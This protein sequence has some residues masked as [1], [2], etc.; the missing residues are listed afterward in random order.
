MEN[1]NLYAL[2]RERMPADRDAACLQLADLEISW[3]ELDFGVGRIAGLLA[4]LGSEPGARLL[5]QVEKSPEALMLYLAALRAGMVYVPLN[6]AYQEAEL[7]HFVNDSQPATVVCSPKRLAMFEA[8]E[9]AAKIFSLDE[10]GQGTLTQQA[11]DFDGEFATVFCDSHQPAA[12]LYTSG[13]TGRSKG[14]VLTHG[15]LCSNALV[16]EE[17][18]GFRKEREAGRRDVLLHALPLFHVHGLFVACHC[19]LLSGAT[20][21]FLPRFDAAQIVRLLPLATVMMGVPTFYTRLLQEPELNAQACATMRLFVSGSAPLLAET[22]EQFRCRTGHTLLERYGM[23]ETLMLASN[24]YFG[25]PVCDRI[26]GTV[27]RALPGVGIRIARADGAPAASGEVGMVEVRGPNIFT[28]Y[29]RLPDKTREE[30]TQ[31][32][33]FR[34]GDLGCLGAPGT[35]PE[36]LKL[37]GRAKDLIITGGYNVYPKEIEGYIDA[38]PGVIESAVVGLPHPD[39]GEAVCAF[40]VMEPGANLSEEQVICCLK[41]QIAGFKVP[42]RIWQLEELPRNA[43]GKVQKKVLREGYA[44]VLR[45]P[46]RIG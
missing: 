26:A 40:V 31:D 17:Y 21:I 37:V 23:S 7:R 36:Y 6:T 34:T 30:F 16:L 20:T 28:G 43:M 41:D 33:W 22:F 8:L 19:A 32:G 10:N 12:I 25:D 27:G 46:R 5:V 42:K 35:A 18:W 13:T 24:P 45:L 9:P 38:L 44:S 3:S 4:S 14:A 29:W 15:N 2:I 1:A 11:A 39:F